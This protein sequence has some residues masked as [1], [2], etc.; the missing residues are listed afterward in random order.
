MSDRLDLLLV[1]PNN[2]ARAYGTLASDIAAIT[3]P[4]QAGLT[5]AYVREQGYTVDILDADADNL[6][7]AQ[8]AQRIREIDPRVAIVCTDHVNSGDV[9]K[10]AAAS[11]LL[12]RLREQGNT[13]PIML[14]G[15]VPTAYP[16]QMLR[17][18]GADLICEGEAFTPV[19]ELLQH[20][21]EKGWATRLEENQIV[22][23]WARYG[24]DV[25]RSVRAPLFR[26]VDELPMTAWDLIPP[27]KYRAHIWQC[28]DDLS[29]RS[30][31]ATLATNYGCPY[32]CTFC[33]VNVVAG[34]S[35]FRP[36]SPEKVLD[37]ID[38]LV[39]EHGVRTIRLLDN[40][41]TI[42]LDLAEQIC[43]MI[44]ERGYDLNMW[45]YARVESIKH[46]DILHKMKRAGINWLV[47]GIE[48]ASE[49]V[50]VGVDKG[51][52]EQS[53]HEALHWTQEAGINILGNFIFGLPGDDYEAM[54]MS[55]DMAVEYNFEW[56][57]FYC[58]MA[59]PGTALH[60]QAL[61]EGIALPPTWSG[62]GHFSPD[63]WP[64]ST[65][66]LKPHEILRFRDEKVQEYFARPEYLRMMEKK[67]GPEI[68]AYIQEIYSIPIPRNYPSE[69][70]V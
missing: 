36:R 8:T 39:H 41:F 58:A 28:F 67:F 18:E 59:Y 49:R 12:T 3:P 53:I 44:I 30:P 11:E 55:Y 20:L 69:T 2:R 46:I 61:K 45:A 5:A 66:H 13:V 43:D 25:V 56:A 54:Q 21:K 65:E 42:R 47:Y 23:V 17:N 19:I 68:V 62:Y 33:S 24:N 15:V 14:E 40:V 60:E 29:K 48:S 6:D 64:L 50:R 70:A 32:G 27:H 63:A 22:G 31:Y 51:S 7:A 9:T 26:N 34:G 38:Y 57:N 37:E 4:V 52:R 16:E 10:M 1:F 35:N